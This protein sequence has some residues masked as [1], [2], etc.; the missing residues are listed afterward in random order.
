MDA[1]RSG[2][3][4]SM[5]SKCVGIARRSP[6]TGAFHDYV[7]SVFLEPAARWRTLRAD[8]KRRLRRFE[9]RQIKSRAEQNWENE[10]GSAF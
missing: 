4:A 3:G 2:A 9:Q 10:G 1:S 6:F 5:E 8:Q 7:I